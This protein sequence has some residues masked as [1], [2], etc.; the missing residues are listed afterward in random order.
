MVT[1]E[2]TPMRSD[3]AILLVGIALG[4]QAFLGERSASEGETD[5]VV[6]DNRAARDMSIDRSGSAPTHTLGHDHGP[7]PGQGDRRS[8][9]WDIEG[10]RPPIRELRVRSDAPSWLKE[11][12]VKA[13]QNWCRWDRS[14]CLRVRFVEH[15]ENVLIRPAIAK[16]DLGGLTYWW[17]ADEPPVI[18]IADIE[19]LTE[20]QLTAEE[21][22]SHELGHAL[23][24][25]VGHLQNLGL[26][27]G[28]AWL[29]AS[30]LT[31]SD[32]EMVRHFR[33]TAGP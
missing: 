28:R 13:A 5:C 18:L 6:P 24:G 14:L 31:P 22:V 23:C 8:P 32:V 30:V 12:T 26:M 1:G 3:L 11:A 29:A 2:S 10:G 33:A 16:D 25:C 21:I 15:R 9:W 19:D 17:A 27:D 4:T 20:G 7:P